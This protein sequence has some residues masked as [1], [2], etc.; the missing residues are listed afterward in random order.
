MNTTEAAAANPDLRAG[1]A[2]GDFN[3]KGVLLG[4]VD[5][6][7]VLLVRRGR[8]Y[9]AV[10]ATCTH[11]GGPLAEGLLVDD[12]VRCPWH[13]ACFS[14][15]SGAPLRA[16]ALA[17]LSCYR[18]EL[19]GGRLFVGDKLPEAGA[20]PPPRAGKHPAS[21]L[22]IGGGAAGNAAAE[23]LRREGYDGPIT[24]L[25]ADAALPVDRPNLSKNYLAGTAEEDWIPL[26]S[27]DFYR[28]RKID[29]QLDTRITSFDAASRRAVAADG[30]EF[31]AEAVLLATG[32]D[33]IKL[34]F[35]GADLPHVRYLRSFADARA[36]IDRVQTARRAVVIGA[37]FIGLEVAASL[38]NRGLEVHVVGR[39]T[40]LMERVL[41]AQV[42]NYLQKLHEQHGVIFHLGN[43]PKAIEVNS[44]S[45]AKGETIEAELVVIGVGVRPT[46]GL[47][48]QAGLKLDRGVLV[49]SY[50][51]TS[52]PGVFAAGDIA[53][54]PDPHSGQN[55]RVEHWVVAERM[56]QT[57]A[58]NIL[59]QRERFDAVPFFWTE[60]YDF[61][62][63]Y[64]GHAEG[65]DKIDIDGSIE[66]RDCTISYFREG[67]KLAVC[68]IGRDY[69]NLQQELAF[70]QMVQKEIPYP[71]R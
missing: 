36:L 51:E 38:R 1:V 61:Q 42:G 31:Q 15:H 25:S 41:G 69:A 2:L 20:A 18:V 23:T 39:E 49:D 11:Y 9:Y 71:L 47:A 22:I 63:G 66:A 28:E 16:P 62:L 52:A 43:E 55:I 13:H 37:S 54:W 64:T 7:A 4:Q 34:D 14:L 27:A 5:G 58:R 17:N 48:E 68:T 35:P 10:S 12:T 60:Q 50:L 53:R 29:V 26:R 56:A 32:A 21:V 33:P 57:A 6:E 3:D 24:L 19:R 65:V 40:V 46:L 45:L 70:E 59:G 67:R 44:V 8:D 30:R